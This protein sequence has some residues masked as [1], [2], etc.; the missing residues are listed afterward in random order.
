[1]SG[2]NGLRFLNPSLAYL[3]D[4]GSSRDQISG[5]FTL[6]V[7]VSV[8]SVDIQGFKPIVMIHDGNDQTQFSIWQWGA[9]IIVMNGD[10]YD[11]SRKTPRI[12]AFDVLKVGRKVEIVFTSNH[13]GTSLFLAGKLV[14]E[15]KNLRLW[16]PSIGEKIRLVLGNSVYGKHNW[17][18]KMFSLAFYGKAPSEKVENQ[19][20]EQ[21]SEGVDLTEKGEKGLLLRYTFDDKDGT[22]IRD[23][24]GHGQDLII[25]QRFVVLKKA[26]LAW[27]RNNFPLKRWFI[28]DVTL[29]VIGFIPLGG[30]LFLWGLLSKPKSKINAGLIVLAIC[31][32]LSFSIEIAQAWLPNRTSSILDVALNTLG[33]LAGILLVSII[34]RH[35][36]SKRITNP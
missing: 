9:S 7:T 22:V 32:F 26:F 20:L 5:E 16:I 23:R 15:D 36:H 35:R 11:Y 19:H 2:V 18:G 29:N 3:D 14:K 24:S 10:H 6:S 4:L 30:V 8:A 12:S 33:S 25:P 21:K 13:T 28:T 31:F 1:M 34:F 27:P 17:E